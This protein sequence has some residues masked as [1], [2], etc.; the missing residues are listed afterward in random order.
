MKTKKPTFR[1]SINRVIV[2]IVLCVCFWMN[3]FAA[4]RPLTAIGQAG[5]GTPPH[6]ATAL[7]AVTSRGPLAI[8]DQYELIQGQRSVGLEKVI[9]TIRLAGYGAGIFLLLFLLLLLRSRWKG[10]FG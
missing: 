5:S 1:S 8:V 7:M 9:Q 3:C 6:E 10:F 4:A 2:P